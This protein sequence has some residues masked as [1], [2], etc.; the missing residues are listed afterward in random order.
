MHVVVRVLVQDISQSVLAQRDEETT[1]TGLA[2]G[3]MRGAQRTLE[4]GSLQAPTLRYVKCPA[5]SP[6]LPA[7]QAGKRTAN[8]SGCC[9]QRATRPEQA[10]SPQAMLA[11]ANIRQGMGASKAVHGPGGSG[12]V[13]RA[14]GVM[15]GRGRPSPA[16][17][18]RGGDGR[19]YV[20]AGRRPRRSCSQAG[21][22]YGVEGNVLSPSLRGGVVRLRR[23]APRTC[24]LGRTAG[25]RL[26]QLLQRAVRPAGLDGPHCLPVE[27]NR[28]AQGPLP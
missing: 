2:R 19:R 17:V 23:I 5:Y 11:G 15:E 14:M 26:Q 16:K 3:P 13:I 27:P 6:H 4:A 24:G 20:L 8:N 21:A 28:R 7:G 22:P 25:D 1:P 9:I 10:E 12:R 18:G